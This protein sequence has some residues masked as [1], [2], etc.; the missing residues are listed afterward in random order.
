MSQA[1]IAG[2]VVT[3]PNELPAKG[4]RL[5]DFTLTSTLGRA[6]HLSDYRGHANLVL[7]FSDDN[8]ETTQ[9]MSDVAGHYAELKDEK[10]DVLAIVRAIPRQAVERTYAAAV[11][12]PVLIDVDGSIHRRFGAVDFHGSDSSAVYITDLFG[13][14]SA[15]YRTQDGQPLPTVADILDWLAF[16]NIQCP[17]CEPPEWPL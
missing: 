10:T 17:E 5:P 14:V 4:Q 6:I 2:G 11:P 7:I 13:E 1:E 16:I 3:P 9:L 15:V 8:P 12:Y